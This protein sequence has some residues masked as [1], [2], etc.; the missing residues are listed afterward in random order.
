M[1]ERHGKRSGRSSQDV[2]SSLTSM[3]DLIFNVLAFFVVTF[4]VPRP[5]KNFDVVLPPPSARPASDVTVLDP[6]DMAELNPFQDLTITLA[7]GP[8]GALSSVRIE[9]SAVENGMAGLTTQLCAM[10]A[11]IRAGN[12]TGVDA[13]TIAAS[14]TL[15][16]RFL[17]SAVDSCHRAGISKINFARHGA[18][19][20]SL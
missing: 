19:A 17:M 4:S 20:Q 14:P 18:R 5:E 8:G 11:A 2:E 16:Y 10:R 12:T 9:G 13:V 1:A 3:L 15:K 6:V 7:T